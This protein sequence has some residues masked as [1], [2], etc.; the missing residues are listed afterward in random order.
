MQKQISS[1]SISEFERQ[2][3]NYLKEYNLLKIKY[4]KIFRNIARE[5]MNEQ[6]S[7]ANN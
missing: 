2:R 4:S 5:A 3:Q 6:A 7:A 1:T